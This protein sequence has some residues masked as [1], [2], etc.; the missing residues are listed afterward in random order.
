MTLP[1]DTDAGE[2][3][4]SGAAGFLAESSCLGASATAAATAAGAADFPD[5][6]TRVVTGFTDD[7]FD[8]SATARGVTTV[9]AAAR[10]AL[11]TGAAA[12]GGV[13]GATSLA[14]SSRS[15]CPS[16]PAATGAAGRRGNATAATTSTAAATTMTARSRVARSRGVGGFT[17][18]GVPTDRAGSTEGATGTRAFSMSGFAR[19]RFLT[20][21]F[22]RAPLFA[23]TSAST[24]NVQRML[25]PARSGRIRFAMAT[26]HRNARAGRFPAEFRDRGPGRYKSVIGLSTL[27]P[28][29]LDDQS[30]KSV[31][32]SVGN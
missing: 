7:F 28:R 14:A 3:G 25:R 6:V 32:K 24:S 20:V 12:I 5:P 11:G 23:P 1:V 31:G 17:V 15:G 13:L 30:A 18:E 19:R 16:E 22:T 21:F 9:D 27:R 29:R 8:G 2:V 26:G 4:G 10:A